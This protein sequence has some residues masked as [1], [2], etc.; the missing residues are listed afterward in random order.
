LRRKRDVRYQWR[1]VGDEALVPRPVG[2][3]FWL[4]V[5]VTMFVC[6]LISKKRAVAIGKIRPNTT[7]LGQQLALLRGEAAQ[8]F[9]SVSS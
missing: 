9:E 2:V 3:L 7:L 4:S 5:S 8:C 1:D 6:L